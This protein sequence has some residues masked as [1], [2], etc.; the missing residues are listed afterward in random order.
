MPKVHHIST[1]THGRYL[2]EDAEE[3]NAPSLLLGFHGYTENADIHLSRLKQ[4]ECAGGAH[5]CSVQALHVFYKQQRVAASWMCSQ[6]RE[7]HITYNIQYIN[8][9]IDELTKS[10]SWNQLILAG[11]SQ[12]AAMAY[13]YAALGKHTCHALCIN[14]GDVPPDLE[15][16]SLSSLPPLLILRGDNDQAYSDEHMHA[17]RKRLQSTPHVTLQTFPGS[18]SWPS[19]ASKLCT[20]FLNTI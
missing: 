12:G 19:A 9:V 15:P 10:I 7:F 16:A 3:S 1:Q 13:R 2:L 17:D 4:I 6:D 8:A 11:F 14:G 20:D 5:Y 18:H